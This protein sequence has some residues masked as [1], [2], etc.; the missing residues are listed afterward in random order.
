MLGWTS[1]R[2]GLAPQYV[3]FGR[4]FATDP[5]RVWDTL[6]YRST[7]L[8]FIINRRLEFLL[9]LL[10]FRFPAAGCAV[11]YKHGELCPNSRN[12]ID[13]QA[14]H[15]L[16]NEVLLPLMHSVLALQYRLELCRRIYFFYGLI[17]PFLT[18]WRG[19]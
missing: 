15:V 4:I 6:C 11:A 1:G 13:N 12:A 14:W 18:E 19:L 8:I 10:W 7:T 2:D 3:S 9:L 5:L 16:N 17:F